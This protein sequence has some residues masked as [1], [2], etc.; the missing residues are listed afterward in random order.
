MRKPKPPR[1]HLLDRVGL[2]AAS[3]LGTG[4]RCGL[5]I[6]LTE[7]GWVGDGPQIMGR[8]MVITED[9]AEVTCLRCLPAQV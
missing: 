1:V 7:T 4:T 2:S 3:S 8:H 5:R 6:R 9:P